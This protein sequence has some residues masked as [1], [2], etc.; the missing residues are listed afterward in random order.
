[1]VDFIMYLEIIFCVL[2]IFRCNYFECKVDCYSLGKPYIRI[3]PPKYLK[4]N[5]II[6]YVNSV[7]EAIQYIAITK[8]LKVT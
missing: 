2:K 1:M 7:F 8:D 5:G 3:R 4:R 6:N